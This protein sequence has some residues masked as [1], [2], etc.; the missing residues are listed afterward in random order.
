MKRNALVC[1]LIMTML[2]HKS[3]AQTGISSKIKLTDAGLGWAG[4]SINTVVF[5]KNSL[6]SYKENQFISYYDA[7]GFVI[8]GKRKLTDTAWQLKKTAYKGNIADAHNSISIMAD[9]EGFLHLAWDHHN[10]ILKYCKS[11][12]PLSLELTEMG[13]MT[14]E[15][16]KVSYPEFYKMPGGNLLFFYRD[17]SSGNGNLVINKYNLTDKKWTRLQSSL[18]NGEGKRNAYW[19]ACVD[20]RGAIHIS[21]VWRENPDV[22]SNHDMCYA[23]SYDGG[24]SWQKSNGEKYQLPVTINSAEKIV[25]ISQNTELINQTSMCTDAAGNPFI[26][27]YWKGVNNVPQYHIICKKGKAWKV[28]DLGFRK[29]NFTLSG[30]GT[31][32]IPV[33]RPQIIVWGKGKRKNA[34]IIF[35]DEERGNKI[36]LAIAKTFK[37]NNWK[38]IDLN[39]SSTGVWEPTYDTELWKQK[40]QLHLFVQQV[41]QADAEAV[42]KT[43]PKMVQVLEFNF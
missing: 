33:S 12:E 37:K 5:R 22:A 43:A 39:S 23:V 6:V 19:Q 7:D 41:V 42:I 13:P 21:W 1:L 25:S 17:G 20:V 2:T 26:A 4:N 10:S 8:I 18:I 36:S 32:Q 15:E 9:G 34:A 30:K 14:G 35:R 3:E 16:K 29:T 24:L 27:S 11:I 31:K 28:Q 38:L 40:H